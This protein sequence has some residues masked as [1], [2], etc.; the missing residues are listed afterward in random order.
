MRQVIPVDKLIINPENYRFDPVDTQDQAIDL[1]IEK[2]GLEILALAKHILQFGLDKAK[3]IR[4]L[5]QGDIYLVLDGNRRITV[6]KC[7]ITPSLIKNNKIKSE[8]EKLPSLFSKQPPK[9][10]NC[11]VYTSE[12]DASEWIRLDHTGKNNGVGQDNWG[13]QETD[14]FEFKFGGKLSPAMQIL[15]LLQSKG[16]SFDTNRLK[17]STINRILSYPSLRSFLGIDIKQNNIKVISKEEDAIIRLN[18]L[19]TNII[20]NDV[21]VAS[22][23]DKDKALVFI[24]NLFGEPLKDNM[25]TTMKFEP[26]KDINA[27]T[28]PP[29][30]MP[31]TKKVEQNADLIE[32]NPKMFVITAFAGLKDV[33]KT[34]EKVSS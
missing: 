22:V 19:F 21:K 16:Y 8:F 10:I 7:L 34:I 17:I 4:V 25:Q 2:K 32:Q 5:Q 14:R 30:K 29:I 27:L 28:N 11:Y 26:E 13:A 23:Y 1:M 24:K 33:Y 6:V 18:A 31:E 9:Q 12:K 3:D 15:N 20:D